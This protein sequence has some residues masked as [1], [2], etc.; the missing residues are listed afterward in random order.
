[1]VDSS[2]KEELPMN[3]NEFRNLFPDEEVCRQCLEQTIWPLGRICL[4]ANAKSHGLSRVIQ[5]G[6]VVFYTLGVTERPGKYVSTPDQLKS[7][8][9]IAQQAG[10]RI[11]SFAEVAG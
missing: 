11:L 4:T 7:L 6:R 1:M 2:E 5:K 3:I 10:F 9:K 8:V